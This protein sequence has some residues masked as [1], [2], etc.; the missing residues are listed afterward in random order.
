MK[1][2]IVR[3]TTYDTKKV[4]ELPGENVPQLWEVK[5]TISA[6]NDRG[7]VC[8]SSRYDVAH[9][10]RQTLVDAGLLPVAYNDKKS[11]SNPPKTP[12]D[13]ILELLEI[14]GVYPSGE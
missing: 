9:V 6:I 14:L 1:E 8:S 11:N 10:E 7:S 4:Y 5:L 2:E 12:Q 13:L 3:I